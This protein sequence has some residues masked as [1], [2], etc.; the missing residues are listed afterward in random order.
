MWFKPFHHR[1]NQRLRTWNL[2]RERKRP[3]EHVG[4]WTLMRQR[5]GKLKPQPMRRA[6][7]R[8]WKLRHWGKLFDP[9]I[10]F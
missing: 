5:R 10:P 2:R 6:L 8:A 3:Y 4:F 9:E 1:L 7:R